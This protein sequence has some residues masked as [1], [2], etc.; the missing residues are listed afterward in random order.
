MTPSSVAEWSTAIR[1]RTSSTF[2]PRL[3]TTL[4]SQGP[5]RLA[6]RESPHRHSGGYRNSRCAS[7]HGHHG[8]FARVLHRGAERSATEAQRSQGSWLSTATE[9]QSHRV[10]RAT[11]A[12]VSQPST[13]WSGRCALG[14]ELIS[15]GAGVLVKGQS[16]R[17][18]PAVNGSR[19]ARCR[20]TTSPC[21]RGSSSLPR[22]SDTP[23]AGRQELGGMD[24]VRRE[25]SRPALYPVQRQTGQPRS[26]RRS[27]GDRQNEDGQPRRGNMNMAWS[28]RP[29]GL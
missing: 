7:V 13:R 24:V 10:H 28:S 29:R 26:D 19:E 21:E 8:A 18:G 4:P 16:S 5:G 25:A 20:R 11:E 6:A 2:R 9:A 15:G 14:S 22:K 17:G 27:N 23:V 12:R 3:R 1:Q